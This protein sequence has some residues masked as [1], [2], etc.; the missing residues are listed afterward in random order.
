MSKDLYPAIFAINKY[1]IMAR[2]LATNGIAYITEGIL[3]SA[4]ETLT[5]VLSELKLTDPFFKL[6]KEAN[7]RKVEVKILYGWSALN[8]NQKDALL[9]L[10]QVELYY[11]ENIQS[12]CCFNESLMLLSSMNMSDFVEKGNKHM[13]ILLDRKEDESLYKE[14][15]QETSTMFYAAKK[16][17]SIPLAAS[18]VL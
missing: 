12:R 2:F 3:M 14:V 16:E 18:A 5:L 6:L 13:G 9:R 1:I 11:L 17:T 7:D 4:K 15:V 10:A 8:E